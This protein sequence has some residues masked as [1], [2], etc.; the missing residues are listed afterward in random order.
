VPR[1]L[2]EWYV[3]A[4]LRAVLPYFQG[5]AA[6]KATTM[7]HIQRRHLDIAVP[8]LP[9]QAVA[10]LA[11]LCEPLWTRALVAERELLT[12]EK[13]S[14]EFHLRVLVDGSVPL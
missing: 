4:Q 7:G 9:P 13:Y 6:D 1:Q 8:H 12:L 11:Q 2:P 10:H 14:E 3:A 5:I